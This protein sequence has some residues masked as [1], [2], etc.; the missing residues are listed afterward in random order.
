M[1]LSAHEGRIYMGFVKTILDNGRKRLSC[2][3]CNGEGFILEY[4][5]LKRPVKGAHKM[6]YIGRCLKCGHE[7]H[8][9]YGH[10]N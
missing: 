5:P 6:R 8:V 10:S 2:P 7:H 4:G 9:S 1:L 3:E